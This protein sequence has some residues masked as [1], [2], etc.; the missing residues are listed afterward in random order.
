MK[1]GKLS[2]SILKRSVLKQIKTKNDEVIKGAGV[3]VDCAFLAWERGEREPEEILT[4]LSVQSV[5]LP[6][7][8]A[9]RL[10]FMAAVNNLAAGGAVPLAV[11]V[12]LVLPEETEEIWLKEIMK[13]IE[14]CC[15]DLHMEIAGGHTEISGSVK[16]PVIT[17]TAIGKKYGLAE[18]YAKAET[19]GSRSA[20]EKAETGGGWKA[21]EKTEPD[22]GRKTCEKAEPDDLEIVL[23]KW[24]GLE[25]TAIIAKEK[26]EELL[27]R[28]PLSLIKTAQSF[29]EYLSVLPEA[30]TAL[31]SGT[32]AM[33]DSRNGGIFAALWEL[34]QR[35]GVG[36]NIDLKK[37]PVKQE[38]IEVCEFYDLNPYELLSGGSLLMAA[39]DGKELVKELEKQGIFAAVIGK[40]AKGNQKL[41]LNDEEVRYLEPPKPDEIYRIKW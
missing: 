20:C 29:E 16:A 24:I 32:H 18:P 15:K 28:Y 35:M 9:G 31:K 33:H 17:V 5:S 25:G 38:T 41:I 3:G 8:D 27:S 39:E 34:S 36:L 22:K 30:A 11:M 2:E 10:A 6:V 1:K 14:G 7:R 26:E 23:S 4:A 40:T 21:C 19:G 13:Q 37:I 12:S